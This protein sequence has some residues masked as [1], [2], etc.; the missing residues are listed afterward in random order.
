MKTKTEWSNHALQRTRHDTVV[1]NP[2]VPHAGSL[3][4]GRW[5]E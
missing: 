4:F 5:T 1:G 2:F 3:S